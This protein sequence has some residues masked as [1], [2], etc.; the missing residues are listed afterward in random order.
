LGYPRI[1]LLFCLFLRVVYSVFRIHLYPGSQHSNINQPTKANKQLKLNSYQRIILLILPSLFLAACSQG[2][3]SPQ[4]PN[5]T[6]TSINSV[7]TSS[8]T[9]FTVV[10][11]GDILLHE[12]LWN[13][14]KRDGKN[15]DWDFYPQLAGIASVTES[16][17][18]A[19]CHLETPIANK[20]ENY[21]G[22]PV[23]NSP[24][25]ILTAVKSLGFD[26][27]DQISNH[28]LDKGFTGLTRTLEKL[29]EIGIPHTGTARTPAE[30]ATPLVV[31]VQKNEKIFKVGIIA[32]A[33]SFN[34]FTRDS[35]KLWSAN[36]IDPAA[37]IAEAKAAR[38][39]GAQFVIA[40]I[41]W[42]EEYTNQPSEFQIDLA[43][44][45]AA[46]GE[47]DL[48]DGAHS[49]SVQPVTK[50][51]NMWVAYSHGNLIAAHREPTTIKSEGLIV[52]WTVTESNEGKLEISKVE[53]IPILIT[54]D[55]PVRVLNLPK[56]LN[57]SDF[58]LA[59]KNRMEQALNR[60]SKVVTSLGDVVPVS[61]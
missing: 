42:G 4:K 55:F 6:G 9:T 58:T 23:F 3:A 1:I 12:R 54:D 33:Y 38:A 48:I 51:E 15:G 7:D 35:D 46:S 53:Q 34:G 61:N 59:S 37:M 8:L 44:E 16:A 28:S 50:I 11:T 18:L 14:A 27:C 2:T 43:N 25:E 36:L 24:P 30:A 57:E 49:H 17:D 40:K 47:I 29:D 19:L 26:M 22:Y 5:S 45:L 31:E 13:Q 10:T 21:S 41:H 60:S 56:T 32:Y 39:A 52:R 20:N